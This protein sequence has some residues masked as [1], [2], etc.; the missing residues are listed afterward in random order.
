MLCINSKTVVQHAVTLM[1]VLTDK[2][3][4]ADLNSIYRQCSEGYF[5]GFVIPP[6]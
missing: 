4:L 2:L 3:T 1:H 6:D 5:S